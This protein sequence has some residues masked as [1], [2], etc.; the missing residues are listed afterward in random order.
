MSFL[1]NALLTVLF[2]NVLRYTMQDLRYTMQRFT[3]YDAGF[4]LYDAAATHENH[5][6]EEL[7]AF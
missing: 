4:T 6:L 7:S 1:R 2:E 3:L 5:L